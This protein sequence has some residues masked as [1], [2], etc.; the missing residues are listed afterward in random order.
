MFKIS[1]VERRGQRSLVLEGRLVPP[2]TTEVESAWKN[3]QVELQGK[4]LVIDLTNVT[5]ISPEGETTLFNL[6]RDGARFS[7]ADVF[8]RHVLRQLA[9]RCRPK[10]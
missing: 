7:C 10:Q 3:A 8:T 4:K 6:M 1:T 2:F 9:R 5:L